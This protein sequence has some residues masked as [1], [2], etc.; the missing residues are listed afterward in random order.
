MK[1]SLRGK[2]FK[3]AVAFANQRAAVANIDLKMKVLGSLLRL[4]D[5][6]TLSKRPANPS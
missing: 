3:P 2:G 4:A 5:K 6:S 1:S